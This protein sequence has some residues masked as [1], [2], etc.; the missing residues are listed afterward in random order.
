MIMH[1]HSSRR[2]RS[3]GCIIINSIMKW[4]ILL[5]NLMIVFSFVASQCSKGK[6]SKCFR[7]GIIQCCDGFVLQIQNATTGSCVQCLSPGQSCYQVNQ[8]CCP[9]YRCGSSGIVYPE[10]RP[11]DRCISNLIIG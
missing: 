4:I 7:K 10:P 1:F 11:G 8:P 9:G 2:Y 5:I 3:N 6:I